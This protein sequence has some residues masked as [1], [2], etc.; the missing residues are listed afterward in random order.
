MSSGSPRWELGVSLFFIA[1]CLVILWETRDIPAGVFE[2]LG[3]APVPQATA[4]IILLL[5]AVVAIGAL[6]RMR[7][8]KEVDV[9]ATEGYRPRP[10]DAAVVA[11]FT[12]VYV[13]LLQER[14]MD[15]A[16][17]TALFLIA[18]IGF[19]SRFSR[20]GLAIGAIIAVATGWGAQFVF[21]R[22]FVV[23]LPGL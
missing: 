2:P 4:T 12:V 3:S 20:Q 23:D 7:W 16:P 8:Q 14:V 10:L 18:A 6:R 13:F 19:L 15:F 17:L 22:V 21:T 9:E 5:S 1:G 11:A